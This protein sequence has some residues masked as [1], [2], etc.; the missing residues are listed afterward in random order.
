[1]D[2]YAVKKASRHME[3]NEKTPADAFHRYPEREGRFK[4]YGYVGMN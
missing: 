2:G 3:H 4:R 1:M